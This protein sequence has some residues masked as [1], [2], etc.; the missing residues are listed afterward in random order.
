MAKIRKSDQNL[1]PQN[2]EAEEAVLGSMLI[3]PDAVFRVRE[4]NLE[5]GDF[6]RQANGEIYRAMLALADRFE[7]VDYLTVAAEL[8]NGDDAM[9]AGL[10]TRTPTSVNVRHY[11]EIVRRTAQ[12]RKLISVATDIV[13]RAHEHEGPIEALYDSV[14]RAFFGAVD[15]SDPKSHLYGTDEA[16]L[17]YLVRQ[18]RRREILVKN[19]YALVVTGLHGLD[20]ILDH[21][22]AGML[23]IVG[24]R[25]SVGKTMMFETLAEF[26]AHKGHRVAF[27]HLELSHQLMLDRRMARHSGIPREKLVRGYTGPETSKAIDIIKQWQDRIVYVHCPGWSAERVVADM[28]RLRARGECD[29]AIVD[30]L[31]K[32]TLP[33]NRGMNSAMLIGQQVEALKTAAEQLGIPVFLGSQVSHDWK[34]RADKRPQMSDLR[35]SGEIE[36]KANQ[37]VMLHRPNE[38]PWDYRGHEEALEAYVDKNTVGGVGMAKLVHVGGR[39]LLADRSK[40]A[41]E[42][43][44][45]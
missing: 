44:P 27:Y 34:G 36:E 38:R 31:Q 29:L 41:K 40:N 45:W 15:M 39:F 42:P 25:P 12:Q 35:N 9:L 18:D 1:L 28:T 10:I 33:Q 3:D 2:I 23:H 11:A 7:P 16:I 37:I 19:P 30:Y 24:A 6:Y 22:P 8:K 32:L 14:S 21:V 13:A 26:N 17:E 20:Q 5:A 4:V 43:I